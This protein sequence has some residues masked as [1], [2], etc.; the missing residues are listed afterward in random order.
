[1][2]VTRRGDM[3]TLLPVNCVPGLA[4]EWSSYRSRRIGVMNR[5]CESV[6]PDI[7]ARVPGRFSGHP[8][9]YPLAYEPKLTQGAL[10]GGD[11]VG[12]SPP[13]VNTPDT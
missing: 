13:A 12:K 11:A 6:P 4:T 3:W 7:V 10:G 5:C 8:T 1:M 2:R 9:A